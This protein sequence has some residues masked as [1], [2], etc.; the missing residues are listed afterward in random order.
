MTSQSIDLE[1]VAELKMVL[2]EE[3]DVLVETFLTD[4]DQ[5][6]EQL[7]SQLDAGDCDAVRATAHSL[8]GSCG[9]LGAQPLMVLCK[10]IEDAARGGSL[11]GLVAH[12]EAAR[13]EYDRVR[14]CL[15]EQLDGDARSALT[16]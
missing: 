9:N 13:A 3:F 6:I 8:K 10:E 7:A 5:R 2:E 4:S 11:D 16:G 14:I 12:L 15:N 1:H